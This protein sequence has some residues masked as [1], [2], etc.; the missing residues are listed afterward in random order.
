MLH[1]RKLFKRLLID[2]FKIV[3]L[4]FFFV[5]R[6]GNMN[7]ARRDTCNRCQTPRSGDGG[8]D[9]NYFQCLSIFVDPL[10]IFLQ[11][12]NCHSNSFSIIWC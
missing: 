11:M 2:P 10:P 7:F 8:G 1:V 4:C 9:G 6:C 3:F 12:I 5:D